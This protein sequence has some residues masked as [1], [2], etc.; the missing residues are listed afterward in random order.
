MM[1]A[2]LLPVASVAV[3][4]LAGCRDDHERGPAATVAP[5]TPP[6]GPEVAASSSPSFDAGPPARCNLL[7]SGVPADVPFGGG[8]ELGEAIPFAGGFA[9]GALRSGDGGRVA[10]VLRVGATAAS[11]VDLGPLSRD[12]PAPQLVARGEDLFAFAYLKR[13]GPAAGPRRSLSVHRVAAPVERVLDFPVETDVSSSYDV[14]AAPPSAVGALVAWD[15]EAGTPAHSF[16]QLSTLSPD[17]HSVRSTRAVHAAEGSDAGDAG[18]PRLA[19][20]PGGYWLTWLARRPEHASAALPVP[21]GEI[22]TPSEEATYGWVEAVPLDA[23][24]M[25]AGA[26]KRLTSTTGHVGSYAITSRD[27]ALLVVAEDEGG[28]GRAGGSLEQVVWHGRADEAPEVTV[29][30]RSGVEEETPPALV[31]AGAG[32]NVD[33]WVS[34]LDVHGDT[35]LLPVGP[36][37]AARASASREPLLQGARLLGALP[38]Q[39]DGRMALAVMDGPRW[40]LRWMACMR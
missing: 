10:S 16:V 22:E 14:I 9:L 28:A 3:L 4:L 13:P 2:R 29:V 7:T 38:G 17:L 26:T 19:P 33:P 11:A 35:L 1:R 8:A 40:T 12:A 25:P 5:D 18:D 6:G 23:L 32:A 20:R 36:S 30:V 21:A 15:D 31:A 34:F 27:A 24:G 37:G 39:G